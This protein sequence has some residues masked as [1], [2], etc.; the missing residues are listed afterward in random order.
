MTAEEEAIW[1]ELVNE[2]YEQ[3]V[4][5]VADGRNMS[6]QEVYDLAD[7]RIYSAKQAIDA[8]LVDEIGG[9][10]EAYYNMYEEIASRYGD[11]YVP[12][13]WSALM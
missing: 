9:I 11:E 6:M 12:I 3:F 8:G 1:Q 7:G 10:E 5:V 2:A 13:I 4:E